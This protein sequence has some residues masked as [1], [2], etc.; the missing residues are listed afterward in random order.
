MS[1]G[2]STLA[3]NLDH[4]QMHGNGNAGFAITGGTQAVVSRSS[5]TSN[6]HGFYADTGAILNLDDSVSF[7]NSGTGILSASGAAIRLFS[8]TVTYN[9]TGL[10]IVGGNIGS[11][12]LNRIFGNAAGNG[13]PSALP[14]Q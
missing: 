13:P 11:Y 1:S 10:S 2:G 4:V 6:V 9:G 5:A 8:S 7:G 3:V 14:L 12:G